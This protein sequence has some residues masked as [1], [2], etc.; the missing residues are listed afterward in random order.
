MRCFVAVDMPGR[1]RDRIGR[2]QDK[3]RHEG[4]GVR[5]VRPDRMHLTLA[6]LG[7]VTTEFVQAAQ[8][9]LQVAAAGH[10]PFYAQ[11]VRLGAFGSP[12]RSR[13]VWLGVKT[14]A[15]RLR[16][17]RATV[18]GALETVGFKP[19]FRAFNPHLTLGR[20]RVPRDV[21][22]L[23]AQEFRCDPYGIDRFVLFESVLTPQGPQ[24][25]RLAEFP[26]GKAPDAAGPK[27]DVGIRPQ[28]HKEHRVEGPESDGSVT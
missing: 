7:D 27:T 28:R 12:G 24:Y 22:R 23:L 13:V 17:L 5:W 9:P 6:F 19:E 21:S 20:L 25:T 3:L 10:R 2:L 1:V 14:G 8:R 4:D 16:S 18:V 11:L 15:D 26:L